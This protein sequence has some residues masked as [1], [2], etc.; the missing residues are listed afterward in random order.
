MKATRRINVEVLQKKFLPTIDA[1]QFVT[2]LQI[3]LAV[4]DFSIPTGTTTKA[5]FKKPSG[6][7]VYQDC[8]ISGNEIK[9]DVHNQ[10]LTEY[11]NVYYQVKLT[12]G[13][14]IL[15]TFAGKIEVEKSLADSSATS[16]ETVVPAFDAAV[17]DAVAEIEE[18]RDSAITYIGNGLDNTLTVEGKA[19]DAGATRKAI[20]E[21]KGDLSN[22]EN[23]ESKNVKSYITEWTKGRIESGSHVYS[24]A[25]AYSP[26][27]DNTGGIFY[28]FDSTKY[29]LMYIL[30]DKND[31]KQTYF[32]WRTSSPTEL[33]TSLYPRYRVQVNA[34]SG[35]TLDTDYLSETTYTEKNKVPKLVETVIRSENDIKELQKSICYV[36]GESGSDS[37]DGSKEHPFKTIQKGIDFGSKYVYVN[38][39]DYHEQLNIYNRNELVIMAV[40][41]PST[42]QDGIY[43]TP[44]IVLKGTED[45]KIPLNAVNIVDCGYIKIVGLHVDYP[46]SNAVIINRSR[47]VE[48]TDCIASN[49]TKPSMCG[50]KIQSSGGTFTRCVARDIALDGFNIHGYDNTQFI[51]CVA[52]N[53]GDDGISHHDGCTGSVIGG[54]FYNCGK[55]GIATPTYGSY[56]DVS[57]VYSHDNRYGLYC[58][59]DST[60]RNS[61][62]RI[63][64][65]VMKNNS[66]NDIYI[67]K[68]DIIGIRNVYDSKTITASATFTEF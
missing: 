47:N 25:H 66:D 34:L 49:V 53:C 28:N 44:K 52:F 68:C 18:E 48:M 59:S 31:V 6:K 46:E 7:F 67:N 12:N 61:K 13:S 43:D 27:M 23:C 22:L 1:V 42:Y 24:S 26:I 16:S 9:I 58:S 30:Y 32:S 60:R 10:A 62:G 51:D 2:G 8:T 4:R 57:N 56:V 20:D 55:G 35:V 36:N 37:N 63:S 45:E 38:V 14:D 21:L 65:C 54:E 41:Y 64:N 33:D 5:F 3:I 11:G 29:K 19:A 17:Q 15:S 39:A 40:G 50:F